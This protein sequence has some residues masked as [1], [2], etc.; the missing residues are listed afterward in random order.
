MSKAVPAICS[1]TVLYLIHRFSTDF[2]PIRVS[3]WID[4]LFPPETITHKVQS[5]DGIVELFANDFRKIF[6]M[7]YFM[8]DR[9]YLAEDNM[10][11]YGARRRLAVVNMA[12]AVAAKLGL[13][14]FDEQMSRRSIHRKYGGCRTLMDAKDTC[15]YTAENLKHEEPKS[16]CIVTHIDTFT[17]KELQDA[18]DTLSDGNIHFLYTWNPTCVAGKSDEMQFRYDANGEFITEVDGSAPYR[19]CLWDF[20]DDS[21]VTFTNKVRFSPN[22]SSTFLAST[23]CCCK[24]LQ[25]FND[26]EFVGAPWL[27]TIAIAATKR[28]HFILPFADYIGSF[29]S[30]VPLLAFIALFGSFTATATTHKVIRL[31]VG[32]H[33]SVVITVPNSHF[34]GMAALVRP[35]LHAAAL[36]PRR[37]QVGVTKGGHKFL[38]EKRK[39]PSGFSVAFLGSHLSHFIGDAVFDITKSLTTDKG[40]PSIPNVRVTTKFEGSE[41]NRVGIALAI[42]LSDQNRTVQS[43]SSNYGYYPLPTISRQDDESKA[44]GQVIQPVMAHGAMPAIVT[45]AA[46]IHAKSEAQTRDFVQRRLRDPA[47]KTH[48]VFTPEVVMYISEFAA[49][50]KRTVL[51]NFNGCLEPISEEEYIATRSKT[52]LNKFY[53]VLPIYDICNYDDRDGFMKREVLSNPAKAARGIC[54]HPASPQGIGGRISLA[55]AAAMK[56]CPFMA[57]GL[58][59]EETTEAV[60]TAC[61]DADSITDTDFTAQDATIDINKRNVELMLLLQ[62]FDSACHELIENWHFTDYYGRVLYGDKGTKREAFHFNGSRGSGSPFTTLGNTPLTA[63]FAYIALR[64][65]GKTPQEAWDALGVYSGDDGLTADLPPVAC[66]K[67]ALALGFL[68]KTT[69]RTRFIPFLGRNYLDPIGGSRSSIHSPLRTLAKL[70]ATLLNIE[71]FT[72]EEAMILKAICF[73]V[74]DRHSDFFGAWSHKV[75]TDAQKDQSCQ[76]NTLKA[77]VLKYPGLHPYF[78]ITALKTGTTFENHPGDF[79]DLFEEEMPGFDWSAFEAWLEHGTGPCP[80]LWEHPE[81]TDEAMTEVGPVTLA[82]GGLDDDANK[83]DY[84]GPARSPTDKKLPAHSPDDKKKR[85]N[86]RTVD[87]LRLPT[88]GPSEHKEFLELVKAKG[89]YEEYRAAKIS[90]ADSTDVQ[91]EKR[92]TR[93]RIEQMV[94]KPVHKPRSQ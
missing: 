12:H 52:Q 65:S 51:G 53:D 74:T 85:K 26:W 93:T 35:F 91:K 82:M 73:Q 7:D 86:Q 10:H 11:K 70:H 36:K 69:C 88:R 83:Q 19:D 68:V 21:L 57:C 71:E 55:Y 60:V 9:A 66:D 92:R 1:V 32:E 41:A 90:D 31:D 44:D 13:P 29:G 54:C 39:N 62:L 42:A 84:P 23:V 79:L 48:S 2:S 38:A 47:G 28:Y 45:G 14:I 64:L 58:N 24:A 59:P 33:R 37:P 46:Y 50:I 17:H 5:P 40:S 87:G 94:T 81:P 89:L 56:E 27:S 18:N 49:H 25:F 76:V 30:Y 78:A 75:L 16:G 61:L 22:F 15:S 34:R 80:R 20:E 43:F 4:W 8:L 6:T 67:A 63:L 3:A 72:A 77:R